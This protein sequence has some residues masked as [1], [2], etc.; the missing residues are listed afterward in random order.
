LINFSM[1][2]VCGN[3]SAAGASYQETIDMY[4]A[5]LN[6]VGEFMDHKA[7]AGYAP[8]N[9]R[10]IDGLVYVTYAKQDDLKHDDVAG[11]GNGLIDLFD[12]ATGNFHRLA[13]GTGA[14]GKLREINSP[15]GIAVTPGG[16]GK[17][18]DQLLVGNFGSG[19]IMMFDEKGFDGLLHGVKQS[20]LKIDGLWGLTFGNGGSAGSRD[21]LFF[22]AGPDG[23]SH[24]LFGAITPVMKHGDKDKGKNNEDRKR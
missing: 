3:K 7:P 14:G 12:P 21:T 16:F 13:T 2:G 6:L 17:H 5:N 18:G 20:P 24:G 8:F 10:D 4:D 15:W 22:S 19:T 1:A 11:P 9:V 23:E